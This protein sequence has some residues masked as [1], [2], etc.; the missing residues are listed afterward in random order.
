MPSFGRCRPSRFMFAV[1]KPNSRPRFSPCTTGPST[2]CQWPNI[3]AAARGLP[4]LR[5]LRILVEDTAAPVSPCKISATTTS[6]PNSAPKSLSVA[7]S[8]ARPLPKQKSAPTT[9]RD[10]PRPSA[11]TNWANSRAVRPD[12]SVLKLSSNSVS[13][14]SFASRLARAVADISRK[15]GASGKKTSRG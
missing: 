2:R 10:R 13:T 6:K 3:A 9:T 12:R 14:P 11:R 7:T 1:G 4:S 15:G 8:P 5:A